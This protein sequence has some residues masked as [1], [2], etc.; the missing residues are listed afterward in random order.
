M[1][2]TDD[3]ASLA[4]SK[5]LPRGKMLAKLNDS[6]WRKELF[7]VV[8]IIRGVPSAIVGCQ[9]PLPGACRP[10]S[11]LSRLCIPRTFGG[12]HWARYFPPREPPS[13]P[14]VAVS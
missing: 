6:S 4:L 8:N 2:V 10:N 9:L 13:R 3:T 1:E 14:P 5:Q 7:L 11:A 12:C